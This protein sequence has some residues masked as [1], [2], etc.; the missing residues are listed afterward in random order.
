MVRDR[1]MQCTMLRITSAKSFPQPF[2]LCHPCTLCPLLPPPCHCP[3]HPA[4]LPPSDAST[5]P[6]SPFPLLHVYISIIYNG[7]YLLISTTL[8]Q[9]YSFQCTPP[10]ISVPNSAVY[11]MKACA[12]YIDL[13]GA[14]SS[15]IFSRTFVEYRLHIK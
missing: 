3:T 8:A 11:S 7:H 14:H 15:P 1:T 12:V 10:S 4:I 13:H 2:Q 5:S 6:F 9:C